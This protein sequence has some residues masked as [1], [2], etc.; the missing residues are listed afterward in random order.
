MT[1]FHI[2]SI[3]TPGPWFHATGE[4]VT[5][6]ALDENTGEI[7]R[8]TTLPGIENAIWMIRSGEGLLIATERFL[9]DGALAL[10]DASLSRIGHLQTTPGGAICHL[11]LSPDGK[12]VY[13]VSYLGGI[14]VHA[15][16]SGVHPVHQSITYHG[17]GPNQ[18]R[19]QKSHPHQ[20]VVSPDAR[21]LFVC[22]LGSD[23]IW[24]HPIDGAELGEAQA[25]VC[26]P[27]CGPRHL[28]FHPSLP[29]F[30]LL[31]ELDGHVHAYEGEG[32]TWQLINSHSALP[33]GF[34]G[35]PGGAAIRIHPSKQSLGVSVRGS[36]TM[37]LFRI[38]DQGK[39]SPAA[40]FP[41][42]G[43]CPRDFAYSPSGQWLL[44][45]NQDSDTVVS[46]E[47]DPT[48]GM[49]TGRIGPIFAIGC[50]TCAVF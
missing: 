35:T 14:T 2:G 10:L 37:A 24:I 18:E 13:A 8:L 30:Y 23:R 20:A 12:N 28:V 29:C 26:P 22:D 49:P 4:G 21:H 16:D 7:S 36:D 46:F 44:A 39:L 1:S 5:E 17:S 48:D 38:S 45:L 11:A 27:G 31:G 9:H 47:L 19:Q 15:M 40:N 32:T 6:C 50:P 25:I 41:T 43:K 33:S 3:N 34:R 42:Q